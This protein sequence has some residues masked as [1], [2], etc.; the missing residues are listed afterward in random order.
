MGKLYMKKKVKKFNLKYRQTDNGF[1]RVEYTRRLNH[2]ILLY[3]MQ[4]SS[5]GHY[6]LLRC[7]QDGEPAYPVPFDYINFIELPKGDSYT[8]IALTKFIIENLPKKIKDI[9]FK[10]TYFINDVERLISRLWYTTLTMLADT[11]SDKAYKSWK[12]Q[13]GNHPQLKV[14]IMK[15]RLFHIDLDEYKRLKGDLPRSMRIYPFYQLWILN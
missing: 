14:P 13:F 9:S 6:E 15:Y 12:K 2:Q 3:C 1:C 10:R 7:S 4:E 8:D 5:K 11:S